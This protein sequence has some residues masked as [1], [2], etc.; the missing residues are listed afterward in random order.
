[1]GLGSIGELPGPF[2]GY[3]AAVPKSCAPF[4]RVLCDNGYAKAIPWWWSSVVAI[5]AV[6][7]PKCLGHRRTNGWVR[8]RGRSAPDDRCNPSRTHVRTT[9][10]LTVVRSSTKGAAAA[11]TPLVVAVPGLARADRGRILIRFEPLLEVRAARG[12]RLIVSSHRCRRRR[13]SLWRPGR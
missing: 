13:R 4:A 6:S 10:G 3:T 5:D 8:P 7:R 2:P 12:V 11:R 9:A 1:M